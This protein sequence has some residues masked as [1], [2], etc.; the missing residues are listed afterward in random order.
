MAVLKSIATG[1]LTAAGITAD[2]VLATATV[3]SVGAFETISGTTATVSDNCIL[4]FAVDCDGTTG[5]INVDTFVGPTV[6]STLGLAYSK[7]GLAFGY[8]DNDSG[9]GGGATAFTFG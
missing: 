3:S 2:T 9:G 6:A 7:D 5:W 8:G 4:E 1:N